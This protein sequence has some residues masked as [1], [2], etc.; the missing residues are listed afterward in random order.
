MF[1]QTYT[2]KITTVGGDGVAAGSAETQEIYGF[3]LDI[4]LNYHA[5]CP[6]TADVTI[7]DATFGTICVKTDNATDIRLAPRMA[8]HDTAAAATPVYDY[9]PVSGPL[10]FSIAQANALTD[11][12]VAIVRWLII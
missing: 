3:L 9:Y 12:L 4:L 2:V 11:C 7:S 6:A 8:T 10:T 1:I 5:S